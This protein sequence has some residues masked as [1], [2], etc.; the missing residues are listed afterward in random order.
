M[1]AK[2]LFLR[3]HC[4]ILWLLLPAFFTLHFFVAPQWR[5][6]NHSN[7]GEDN[8]PLRS[9]KIPLTELKYFTHDFADVGL[10]HKFSELLMGIY[11]ARKNGLQYVFNEKSFVHNYRNADLQWLG[12][13]LRQRYPTPQEVMT[14]PNGQDFDLNRKQWIPVYYYRSTTAEAY[15]EMYEIDLRRPL[16]GFV[17]LNAYLCPDDN[18]TTNDANCFHAEFSFMN[19]TR[20]IR[21]LLQVSETTVQEG[22]HKVEQVDRLV[23]HIRFGDITISEPPEIYV[24]A[25]EGM[26]RKLSISLP[27]SRIHFIYY[28]PSILSWSAWKRLHDLK[29]V[30]PGAQFQNVE[31]VEETIR[32]MIASK[33]LMTSG[34][35]LS[36]VAAYFCPNC[37]VISTMPKERT[38][39]GY[40]MTEENY[41][42]NFYHMD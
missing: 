18:A 26:R 34:S 10:G 3:K 38:K 15:G 16:F 39:F 41:S 29:R 2:K 30:F 11:F 24:K 35:S 32:Y 13:L 31:S 14:E 12:D 22:Q 7:K 27:N 33:Y 6:S 37:H 42:K 28:R 9:Q 20:D 21:N 40:E 36:Y 8:I 19:N 1:M 17:G 25:I 4:L 23:I 5:Y